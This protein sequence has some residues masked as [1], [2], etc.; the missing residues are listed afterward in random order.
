MT[1]PAG[2]VL[3]TGGRGRRYG[4]PKH[5]QPHPAGGTWGGYLAGVFEAVFP[6]GP[7]Q[8]LGGA[9]PDR[10]DLAPLDDPREGPAEALRRWAARSSGNGGPS[11]V[12]PL[13]WWILACDQIRWTPDALAAWHA[14]A[15]AADPEAGCWV[16]ARHRGRL[17]PLGGFLADALAPRLSAL[18]GAAL[19]AL[20]D[21]LPCRIL[22]AA[23]DAWMDQDR[24]GPE[25]PPGDSG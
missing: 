11:Q 22:D 5:L 19:M 10:P 17:Q 4:A 23:G 25:Q 13:R 18:P 7:I 6:G 20:V 21:A 15:A 24:P 9:L 14:R 8:V 3:L 12:H 1:A 2:L 16:L